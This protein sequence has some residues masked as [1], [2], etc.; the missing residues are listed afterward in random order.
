MTGQSKIKRVGELRGEK[1]ETNRESPMQEVKTTPPKELT[2][3]KQNQEGKKEIVSIVVQKIT[4]NEIM[5]LERLL[6]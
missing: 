2:K 3:P 5:K 4:R 1:V 6:P